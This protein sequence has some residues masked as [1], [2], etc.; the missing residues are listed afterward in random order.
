MAKRRE[1]VEAVTDFLFLDSKMADGDCR[2]EIRRWLLHG[3]KAMTNLDRVLKAKTSFCRKKAWI[4]KAMVFPVVMYRCESWTIKKAECQRID[5][6][7]PWWLLRVPWSA[8]RSNQSILREINAEYS[9]E[10]LMLKLKLQYFGHLMQIAN[11]LEKTVMLVK[12]EGRRGWQRMRRLDGITGS[13]D[14][15][16]GKIQEML[17][18]REAWHVAVHRVTKNQTQLG[19]WTTTNTLKD[20]RLLWTSI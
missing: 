4:V 13:M 14:M 5:T 18:D 15:N 19:D 20:W 8:R 10:R 12:T 1:K 16:L 2:H 6:F 17:R 3:R 7:K 9:L 11:F